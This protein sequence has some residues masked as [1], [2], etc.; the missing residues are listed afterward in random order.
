TETATPTPTPTAT[1][2]DLAG[3]SCKRRKGGDPANFP[4]FVEV[5]IESE[6]DTEKVEFRFEPEGHPADA[7]QWFVRFTDQL[8]SDAEGAPV[9][10]AGDAFVSISFM[11]RGV[12]LSGDGFEEIYTGPTEFTPGLS[13]ILEVEQLGDFE[14]LVSW[15]IGLPSRAC[16]VV[17]ARPDRIVLEFPAAP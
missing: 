6:G 3:A 16:F 15:G 5:K 9:D 1:S 2:D 13:T 14:G 17:E 8:L 4:D 7:P 11:A 12:D 10:V